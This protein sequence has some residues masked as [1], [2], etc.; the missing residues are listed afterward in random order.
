MILQIS[1]LE[2]DLGSYLQGPSTS[3]VIL[4]FELMYAPILDIRLVNKTSILIYFFDNSIVITSGEGRFEPW[5][6]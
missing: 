2:I 6:S 4:K 1:I 3:A 5:L